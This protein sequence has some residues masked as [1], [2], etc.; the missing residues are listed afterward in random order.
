M[1]GDRGLEGKT[2]FCATDKETLVR[3]GRGASEDAGAE[4]DAGDDAADDGWPR[5]ARDAQQE[6]AGDR[7]DQQQ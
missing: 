1:P 5:Q 4:Q 3:L 2:L 7:E 6:G